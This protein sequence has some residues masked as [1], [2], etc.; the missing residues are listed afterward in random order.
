VSSQST[1]STAAAAAAAAATAA[2]NEGYQLKNPPDL[3]PETPG[4]Q[5]AACGYTFRATFSGK[6]LHSGTV[7]PISRRYRNSGSGS[8]LRL[9]S[10]P[11]IKPNC[12]SCS[13]D[14]PNP[15][16]G[17]CSRKKTQALIRTLIA[18][19]RGWQLKIRCAAASR[20]YYAGNACRVARARTQPH[21]FR[22]HGACAAPG[23]P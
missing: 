8:R 22:I 10:T 13:A 12:L 1:T 9:H 20:I 16:A 5:A 23:V 6:Q 15:N 3:S 4:A 21:R 14:T 17:K 11:P 7:K 18:R 2:K 19:R